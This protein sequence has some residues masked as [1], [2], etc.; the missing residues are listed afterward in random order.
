MPRSPRWAAAAADLHDFEGQA[1][2][3]VNTASQ[4]G[5]T[6]Q[7]AG[8]PAALR[9]A[10][11]GGVST[12]FGRQEPG[13]ADDIRALCRD[14][15][16]VGFPVFD[17]GRGQR[18]WPASPVCVADPGSGRRRGCRRHLVELREVPRVLQAVQRLRPQVAPE[19]P[20]LDAAIEDAL[21]DRR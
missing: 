18:A 4:C 11:P 17:K 1:I 19:S 20:E 15:Y 9:T 21:P 13:S 7:Y 12:V 16:G 3:V 5:L 8:S 2:L 14:R 10:T 6:P